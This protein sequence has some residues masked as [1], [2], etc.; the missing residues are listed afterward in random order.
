MTGTG[1]IVLTAAP[2]LPLTEKARKW[3]SLTLEEFLLGNEPV[4]PKNF[5]QPQPRYAV[6]PGDA[7]VDGNGSFP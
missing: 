5:R 2:E 1:A 4:A 7:F 6:Q 3:L